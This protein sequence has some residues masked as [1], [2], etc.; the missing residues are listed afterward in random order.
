MRITCSWQ[1]GVDSEEWRARL[2]T[3]VRKRRVPATVLPR[4]ESLL[5]L[6]PH[7]LD[8]YV[9]ETEDDIVRSFEIGVHL[10][11][12]W[13]EQGIGFPTIVLLTSANAWEAK[14]EFSGLMPVSSVPRP[15]FDIVMCKEFVD[16]PVPQIGFSLLSH[17]RYIDVSAR[18]LYYSLEQSSYGDLLHRVASACRLEVSV[19]ESHCL[20]DENLVVIERHDVGGV[21][22]T[23]YNAIWREGLWRKPVGIVALAPEPL[24]KDLLSARV[25]D[26]PIFLDVLTPEQLIED[27]AVRVRRWRSD[28]ETSLQMFYAR[29]GDREFG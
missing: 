16:E 26:R 17:F 7:P 4:A 13:W 28:L 21:I 11:R 2:Q 1:I 23:A 27:G 5:R 8:K 19:W 25:E 18:N 3:A 6:T 10:A 14:A 12:K 15:L 22:T 24:H 29:W 20:L 9:I